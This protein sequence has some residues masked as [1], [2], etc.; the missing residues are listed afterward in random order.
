[1]NL[2][3]GVELLELPDNILTGSG[4]WPD[5]RQLKIAGSDERIM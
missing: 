2:G 5:L 3:S 4:H 1:M